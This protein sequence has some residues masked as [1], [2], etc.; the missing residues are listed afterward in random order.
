MR[1]TE[2]L[3]VD[4]ASSETLTLCL[5][6]GFV[7][8]HADDHRLTCKTHKTRLTRVRPSY[9]DEAGH[10]VATNL[11]W[12]QADAKRLTGRGQN[13]TVEKKAGVCWVEVTAAAV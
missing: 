1:I 11:E 12:C 3:I 7:V 8:S 5:E 10:P 13:A 9:C 4:G 2:F 6:C